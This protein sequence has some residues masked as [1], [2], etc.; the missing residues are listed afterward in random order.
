MLRQHL[1]RSGMNLNTNYFEECR[2]WNLVPGKHPE[3]I[4][5]LR[6]DRTILIKDK[7]IRYGYI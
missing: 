1:P 6:F 5:E 2:L 4:D 3:L 7:K